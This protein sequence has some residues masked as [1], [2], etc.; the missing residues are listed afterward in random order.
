MSPRPPEHAPNEPGRSG[1]GRREQLKA[2]R[3]AEIVTKAA[4]LFIERGYEGTSVNDVAEALE[5][6]VGGLYRYITTK[7]DLLTLVCDDIYGELPGALQAISALDRAPVERLI[8]VV[9]A[10]LRAC[11]ANRSLILLMYR[12]YRHLP[13]EAQE[14]YEDREEQIVAILTEL[15]TVSLA[16]ATHLDPEI[17]ARDIVLLGHLPALKGWAFR[18]RKLDGGGLL[19]AQLR[20]ISSTIGAAQ[21]AGRKPAAPDALSGGALE[22]SGVAR[23]RDPQS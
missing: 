3:R 14:R 23:L 6:S 22:W 10:Y 16:G 21:P 18:S 20:I 7:S 4:E 13:Q 8:D 12:E 1:G 2:R 17:V 11:A 9:D 5:M 19:A 15:A